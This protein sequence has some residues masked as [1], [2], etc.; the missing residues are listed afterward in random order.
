M[1]N[2]ARI[3]WEKENYQNQ[4]NPCLLTVESLVK[5]SLS[6]CFYLLQCRH[7]YLDLHRALL[8]QCPGASRIHREGTGGG[9][10]GIGP[11]TSVLRPSLPCPTSQSCLKYVS[12]SPELCLLPWLLCRTP[13]CTSSYKL[14]IPICTWTEVSDQHAPKRSPPVFSTC[15][16]HHLQHLDSSR[17]A[18]KFLEPPH[19]KQNSFRH[20]QS[21]GKGFFASS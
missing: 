9:T 18:F 21:F 10:A 20:I 15:S 12:P 2:L 16:A 1:K 8:P 5:S 17:S 14:N 11:H 19:P 3:S 6:Y 7:E 4:W 13:D